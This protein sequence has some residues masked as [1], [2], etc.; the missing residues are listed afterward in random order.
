MSRL[1]V[2]LGCSGRCAPA[3]GLRLPSL[4]PVAGAEAFCPLLGGVL[5]LSGVLGGRPSLASSS[6]TRAQSPS[7][8]AKSARI[9]ASFSAWLRESSGGSGAMRSLTH[10]RRGCA[11]PCGPSESIGRRRSTSS[12]HPIPGLRPQAAREQLRLPRPE[13]AIQAL[14]TFDYSPTQIEPW[15]PIEFHLRIFLPHIVFGGNRSCPTNL[16]LF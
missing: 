7:T 13:R 16:S 8:R 3:C 12:Y 2:G 15:Q 10:I 5:E 4:L 14:E 6:A 1:V 11:S 9:R